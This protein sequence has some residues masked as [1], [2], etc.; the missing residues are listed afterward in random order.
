MRLLMYEKTE[1]M[2]TVVAMPIAIARRRWKN[3]ESTAIPGTYDKPVARPTPSPW[4]R[5]T[6]RLVEY[7]GMHAFALIKLL[8]SIGQGGSRKA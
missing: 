8:G 5:N 4:D 7:Q 2:R 1:E 6:C 3:C